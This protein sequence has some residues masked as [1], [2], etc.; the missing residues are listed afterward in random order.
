MLFRVNREIEFKKLCYKKTA[1]KGL[2]FKFNLTVNLTT[3]FLTTLNFSSCLHILINLFISG[4]IERDPGPIFSQ[5]QAKKILQKR[6]KIKRL[7]LNCQSISKKLF[8]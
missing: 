2:S 4:D 6:K 5:T 7:C 1:G 3:A 8:I